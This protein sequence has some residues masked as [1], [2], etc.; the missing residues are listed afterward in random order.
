MLPLVSPTAHSILF[1]CSVTWRACKFWT[2]IPKMSMFSSQ[3]V[4]QVSEGSEA[5]TFGHMKLD[6][7]TEGGMGKGCRGGTVSLKEGAKILLERS[8]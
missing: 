2:I 1:I 6:D 7:G 8:R 3:G 4:S 5:M